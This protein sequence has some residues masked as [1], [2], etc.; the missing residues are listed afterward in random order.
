[1]QNY[2]GVG[3]DAKVALEWH[4]RRQSAPQLFTSRFRNKMQYAR[5]GARQLF[6]R[7]FVPICGQLTV[8]ADGV[9]LSLPPDT[10]GIIILNIASYGGGSDLWG[11][12]EQMDMAELWNTEEMAGG[13]SP[14]AASSK[15]SKPSSHPSSR[16]GSR[17]ATSS[18]TSAEDW[19]YDDASV[20]FRPPP[21]DVRSPSASEIN[22]A[23]ASASG[24]P[25]S[26]IGSSSLGRGGAL[27]GGAP[28]HSGLYGYGPARTATP[29]VEGFVPASMD[30]RLLEVVAVEGVLQ[31]GLAQMSLTNARRLC[32]CSSITITSSSSTRLPLQVDGE[33]F[34]LEPIFAPRKPMSISITHHNQA[35]MLSRSRVRSD[36]VALEAIDWAMQEGV[37]T[38]EQ[39]N[40]VV[41][42]VAR[43]TGSLQRRALSST[44]FA[45]S[46]LSL[47]SLG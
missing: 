3:V 20:D 22:A 35:V 42:E 10:E 41:R 39:R 33:P 47:P 29:P 21:L 5:Y 34:E 36:G 37:I 44:N 28:L 46:N 16:N 30:D 18:D 12:S 31:L 13:G 45:G 24:T 19:M 40:Q 43:R 8:V 38:V 15:P 17:D 6:R 25:P 7:D 27:P 32:Q 14:T 26:A 1:M 9:T 4:Q 23:A 2:L 11:S